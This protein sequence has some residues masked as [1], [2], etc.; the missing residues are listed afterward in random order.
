MELRIKSKILDF[1]RS[2]QTYYVVQTKEKVYKNS[3]LE[4]LGSLIK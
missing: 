4:N 2:E 1:F 3:Y